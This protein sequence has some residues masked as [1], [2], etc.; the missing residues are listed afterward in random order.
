MRSISFSLWWLQNWKKFEG[1]RG[2]WENSERKEK[3]WEIK[4]LQLNKQ[5]ELGCLHHWPFWRL[6]CHVEEI[7]NFKC[8]AMSI[9]I[10]KSQ[11]ILI[12]IELRQSSCIYYV[13]THTS[14]NHCSATSAFLNKHIDPSLDEHLSGHL[15][16]YYWKSRKDHENDL[17]KILIQQSLK[18]KCCP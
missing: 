5:G 10:L 3:S 15:T 11:F 9:P 18:I 8:K 17:T 13:F 16:K 2:F 6:K 12:K 7:L 4:C 14:L 1:S